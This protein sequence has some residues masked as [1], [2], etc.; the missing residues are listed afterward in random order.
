[1]DVGVSVEVEGAPVKLGEAKAPAFASS[2]G[3]CETEVMLRGIQPSGDVSRSLSDSLS[4]STEVTEI[5]D[6]ANAMIQAGKS[7]LPAAI[8]TALQAPTPLQTVDEGTLATAPTAHSMVVANKAASADCDVGPTKASP[9]LTIADFGCKAC[10]FG[11]RYGHNCQ[12]KRPPRQG[13]SPK[14]RL[15]TADVDT[16]DSTSS[17]YTSSRASTGV[18]GR[19]TP[20]EGPAETTQRHGGNASQREVKSAACSTS[21]A[22]PQKPNAKRSKNN[23]QSQVGRFHGKYGILPPGTAPSYDVRKYCGFCCMMDRAA[24]LLRCSK[25]GNR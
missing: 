25:C 9:L 3:A 5:A 10:L 22:Q 11:T 17:S 7:P 16:D 6:V 8:A 20:K 2:A 4:S 19:T 14:R 1:M 13:A 12:K 18:G 15:S 21:E 24:N 23:G